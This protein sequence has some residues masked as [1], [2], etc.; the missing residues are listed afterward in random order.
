MASRNQEAKQRALE[1]IAALQRY[2]EEL[3]AQDSQYPEPKPGRDRFS[4]Q[5]KFRNSRDRTYTY[6]LL[7]TDN[8]WYCTNGIRY[9]QWQD[10]ANFLRQDRILWHSPVYAMQVSGEPVTA[11]RGSL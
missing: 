11:G 10:V 8:G 5:V 3:D 2:I 6:L 9:A 1:S 4:V 7:R